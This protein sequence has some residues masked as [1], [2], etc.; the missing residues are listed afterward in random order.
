MSVARA[1]RRKPPRSSAARGVTATVSS[2]SPAANSTAESVSMRMMATCTW[3]AEPASY[4][5]ATKDDP[6]QLVP[7]EP[8]R[9]K[10]AN[11][12]DVL[13]VVCHL[14]ADLSAPVWLDQFHE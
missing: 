10:I 8:T 14:D 2:H 13:Q 12:I 6:E 3:W 4:R 9:D 11:L 1:V 7:F 5:K